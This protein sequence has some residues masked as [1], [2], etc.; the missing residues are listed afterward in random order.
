MRKAILAVVLVLVLIVAI[1]AVRTVR[2]A[3]RQIQAEPVTGI[4]VDEE[5][6]ADH[7]ADVLRFRTVSYPDPAKMEYSE[8]DSLHQYL[9][10][11]FPTVYGALESQTVGDHSLLLTWRGQ[12]ADLKPVL[13][14]GHM[15]VVPAD[16]QNWTHPPFSGAIADGYIWG[17]GAL[18]DKSTVTGLLE[19]AEILCKQGFRPQRTVYFAFGHDEELAGDQGAV[20]VAALLKA[21]GI[22]LEFV[23]DEGLAITDGIVPGISRPVALIGIAEKGFLSL[24]LSVES[25]GGH[26]SAP[27]PHTTIG[28]LS[29]AITKLESHQLPAGISG[30][31][32]EMLEALGPEM[33]WPNK[34]ALA[35]LWLFRPVLLSELQKTPSGNSLVRTTTAVTMIEGGVKENVLP[36]SA[37]AIV[38]FRI[39]PGETVESVTDH[40]RNTID[41]PEVKIKDFHGRATNPSPVSS[42][43]STAFRMI[44]TTVRQIFPDTLVAPGLVTG[45]TDSRHYSAISEDTYRFAPFRIT[46]EDLVRVHG[47]NERIAVKDYSAMI[48]F[49]VQLLRNCAG[50]PQP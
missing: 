46:K 26:S 3:S 22:R 37:K 7:L 25:E 28:I 27:P 5:A 14:M 19:A 42:A 32:G 20:K 2:L 44:H 49:Y 38:N 29:Q 12:N 17:R 4:Q 50:S 48:R 33:P 13:L 16:A 6:A 11:T 8:F 9:K 47:I 15:D 45:A 36:A 43:G 1:V 23:M 24:E 10:Q 30:A 41:D 39:K 35:N 31:A 40:V 18:D 34:M 21:Q